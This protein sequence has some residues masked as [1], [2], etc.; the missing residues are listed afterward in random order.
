MSQ[1][2]VIIKLTVFKVFS[3]IN[4][5][6]LTINLSSTICKTIKQMIIDR[7]YDQNEQ[8]CCS[9]L[10]ESADFHNVEVIR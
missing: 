4:L 5:S 9:D 10:S 6:I 1:I 8:Q 2:T 7:L 3:N